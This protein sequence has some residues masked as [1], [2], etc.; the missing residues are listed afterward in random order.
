MIELGLEI[1]GK[2]IFIRYIGEDYKNQ[3]LLLEKAD[4]TFEQ[5]RKTQKTQIVLGM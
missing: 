3:K 1:N 2:N 5:S 4:K